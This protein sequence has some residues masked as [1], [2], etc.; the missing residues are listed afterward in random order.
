MAGGS[1]HTPDAP[2]YIHTH[3]RIGDKQG[4]TAGETRA[5]VPLLCKSWVGRSGLSSSSSIEGSHP[6][7]RL[8][9][10]KEG[11]P[12]WLFKGFQRKACIGP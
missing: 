5:C 11:R 4:G 6:F 7:C 3:T 10:S 12:L 9:A 1:T 2:T 8:K